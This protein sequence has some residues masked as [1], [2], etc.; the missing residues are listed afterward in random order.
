MEARPQKRPGRGVRVLFG[1]AGTFDFLMGLVL[2]TTLGLRGF[3]GAAGED[4][5]LAQLVGVVSIV[6]IAGAVLAFLLAA[7]PR[8]GLAA[9]LGVILIVTGVLLFLFTVFQIGLPNLALGIA[10]LVVRRRI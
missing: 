2:L 10:V 4:T 5:L 6:M 7:W 9:G 1:L 3:A 8:R